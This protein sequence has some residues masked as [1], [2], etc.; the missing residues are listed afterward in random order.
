MSLFNYVNQTATKLADYIA[1]LEEEDD[2][3]E[4]EE[5]EENL[6]VIYDVCTSIS[7]IYG[8]YPMSG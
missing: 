8:A 7:K 6:S 2:D 4:D 5:E 3:E 1:P